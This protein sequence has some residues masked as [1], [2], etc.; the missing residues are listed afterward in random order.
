MHERRAT[1]KTEHHPCSNE[2]RRQRGRHLLL[3]SSAFRHGPEIISILMY[4]SAYLGDGRLLRVVL[5][6]NLYG[7]LHAPLRHP[8]TAPET[9]ST[10]SPFRSP[11]LTIISSHEQSGDRKLLYG[12]DDCGTLAR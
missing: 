2:G 9:T 5:H 3:L 4:V 1:S 10:T 8:G 12:K 7:K 11:E 6:V